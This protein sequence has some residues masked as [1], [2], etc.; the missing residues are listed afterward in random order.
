MENMEKR[1]D[2]R[3]EGNVRTTSEALIAMAD[4]DSVNELKERDMLF[5]YKNDNLNST[6]NLHLG[7]KIAV[8]VCASCPLGMPIK[9]W[10]L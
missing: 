5:I 1:V 6:F 10:L 8:C 4:T 3:Q 9:V 7:L 2:Q